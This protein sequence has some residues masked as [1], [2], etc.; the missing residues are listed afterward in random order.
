[1]GPRSH[2]R[3]NV[4][5]DPRKG[6]RHR[7][8]N[9]AAFSRTRKPAW[10]LCCQEESACFNGAA[11]SR[12]R[13]PG[14]SGLVNAAGG[15]SMGPR[16]HERGNYSA[17]RRERGRCQ[18]SM[19]PR[20]HERGNTVRSA[21]PSSRRTSFNGAAFSRTRKLVLEIRPGVIALRL[22]WGRVLTNAETAPTLSLD[23]T[24]HYLP[25]FERHL[26]WASILAL[27]SY[28]RRV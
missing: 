10:A 24:G 1:M 25:C 11:F 26:E 9:G 21:P 18:A 6:A 3:G 2:E 4:G 19:G 16:S 17:S 23:R 8:F 28:G 5:V 22:Q 14:S 20:S 13:K 27:D 7:C 12:T 15:A